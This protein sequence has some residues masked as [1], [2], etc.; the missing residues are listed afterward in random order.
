MKFIC[1]KCSL[2]LLRC[3]DVGVKCPVGH[4]YDRA[5]EGYYNLLLSAAGGVHGDNR[6]MLLARR[7]FLDTGAYYPLCKELSNVILSHI[8]RDFSILDMGCGEGYYTDIIERAFKDKFGESNICA[9]DISKDAVKLAAKRNKSISFAVASSYKIPAADAS[10]DAV[11]NVFSPL[12]RDETARVLKKDG[13]FVFVIPDRRHL[14]ELKSAV[15]KTPYENEPKSD[16]LEG[17]RLLERK[18]LSYSIKLDTPAMVKDLFS[19]TPYAY[20]TGSAERS[21]LE[22]IDSLE[23]RAEFIIL[24]Y[25]RI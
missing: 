14:W 7:R 10:F 22:L 3:E 25:Q 20:R 5:R 17:F 16:V 18:E 15:Y 19:M 9:F 6:E 13:I 12:A 11:F 8:K 23:C 24:C 21:R 2:P 4:S 1:P